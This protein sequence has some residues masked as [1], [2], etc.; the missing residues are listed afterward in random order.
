MKVLELTLEAREPLV[1][2]DGS[3]ESMAHS[4]LEYIPGSMLLGAFA[5]A[6]L[7]ENDCDPDSSPVF[8]RLFLNGE[9]SWGCA[10]P[11]CGTRDCVPVPFCYMRE[12]SRGAFPVYGESFTPG[13][14]L[15][16]NPLA[17]PERQEGQDE[18]LRQLWEKR[19][20][21]LA[22]KFKKLQASFM[23]PEIMRQP[24]I[25]LVWNTRVALGDTRAAL[26]SQLFGFSAM[27]AGTKFRASIQ[28]E[29]EAA[30]RDLASL[31]AGLREIRVGRARSAGYGLARIEQKWSDDSQPRKTAEQ[32]THNLFL[33]S[34]YLANPSWEAPLGNFIEALAE[35]YGAKCRV[36][37][38]FSSYRQIEGFCSHWKRPRDSRVA[39]AQG[40]VLRVEFEK[41]VAIDASFSLGGGGLEG[42]GRIMAD[43]GFLTEPE[44]E[45]Q[46]L[47]VEKQAGPP[48][49][50]LNLEAP[51]WDILRNRALERAASSQSLAWLED[52]RWQDF[53]DSVRKESRPTLN[54]I[55][56]MLEITP[57][58]FRLMLD[59]SPGRQWREAKA[60]NPFGSGRT[61]LHEVMQKLLD[62][63]EFL[64]T[65]K[66]NSGLI[67]PGGNAKPQEEKMFRERSHALFRRALIRAWIKN[68]R[69]NGREE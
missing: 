43:A 20:P 30:A 14:F 58:D 36:V 47:K 19:F 11:L 46:D 21:G 16:Y 17:L 3:A 34:S 62:R 55:S 12:K 31:L 25:R 18:G 51:F 59:K 32:A 41:P 9:V 24:G 53:L 68:L 8:Q 49:A 10:Y 48:E 28:C 42:F 26:E 4:C 66:T 6:W 27:A 60:A 61:F 39:L 64:R 44:I 5:A 23:N 56:N 37:K 7:R 50:R 67:L 13:D 69:A 15:V 65:F 2:T 38:N 33:L 54:Q 63:E 1:I 45:I 40:S 35:K 29:T 52:S 57:A 22:C